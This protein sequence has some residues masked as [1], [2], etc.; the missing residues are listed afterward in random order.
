MREDIARSVTLDT[1]SCS[2]LAAAALD[3]RL[4]VSDSR[5]RERPVQDARKARTVHPGSAR[6]SDRKDVYGGGGDYDMTLH[7]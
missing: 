1:K 3:M 7:L 6:R 5:T 2:M 4:R